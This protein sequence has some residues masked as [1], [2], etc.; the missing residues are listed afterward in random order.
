MKSARFSSSL[1]VVCSDAEPRADEPPLSLDRLVVCD[2]TDVGR[3]V[4]LAKAE[5]NL[6]VAGAEAATG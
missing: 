5:V 6:S 4:R 2:V 3:L 1:F